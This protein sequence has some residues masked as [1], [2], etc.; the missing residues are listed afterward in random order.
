MPTLRAEI[1]WCLGMSEPG[2]GS[3]YLV[4]MVGADEIVRPEIDEFEKGCRAGRTPEEWIGGPGK[5]AFLLE[6]QRLDPV[7]VVSLDSSG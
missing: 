5:E 3:E 6:P 1:S 4:E 7:R 2:A